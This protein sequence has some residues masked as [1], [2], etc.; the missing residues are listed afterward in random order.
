MKLKKLIVSFVFAVMIIAWVSSAVVTAI[1]D[2]TASKICYSGYKAH[3]SFT[4]FSTV[5]SIVAAIITS[6]IALRVLKR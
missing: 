1:P 3:C 5:I 2:S 4:P 6:L